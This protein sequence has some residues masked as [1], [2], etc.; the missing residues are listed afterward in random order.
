MFTV[1]PG[2]IGVGILYLSY[3]ITG[4]NVIPVM[5]V[6]SELS[7]H[8]SEDDF[9]KGCHQQFQRSTKMRTTGEKKNQ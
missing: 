2:S 3:C 7:Y 5:K 4:E 6:N 8:E 1:G 9:I